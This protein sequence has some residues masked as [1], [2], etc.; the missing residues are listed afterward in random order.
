ISIIQ[1]NPTEVNRSGNQIVSPT[2]I[3]RIYDDDNQTYVNGSEHPTNGTLW[4]AYNGSNWDSGM[5]N[6]TNENGYVEFLFDPTPDCDYLQGVRNWIAGTINTTCYVDQN[7]TGTLPNITVYG[8]LVN[9]VTNVSCPGGYCEDFENVSI[10][11]RVLDKCDNPRNSSWVRFNVS[12]DGFE[13]VCEPVYNET[14]GYF[15]CSWNVTG[16]PGG[17]YD[18]YM[19]SNETYFNNGTAVNTSMFFH[20]IA[21]VLSAEY[22]SPTSVPWGPDDAKSTIYFYV[23]VTDDD[24]N[25]TL[26]LYL[27]KNVSN[28]GSPVDTDTTCTQ[29]SDCINTTKTLQYKF[30]SCVNDI[31]TWYWKINVTDSQG[32][33]DSTSGTDT[34]EVLKRNITFVEWEG[35]TTN[36]SRVGDNTTLIA[37]QV[38]DNYTGTGIG[39]GRQG[40]LWV[41]KDQAASEWGPALSNYTN[42]S[43]VF[44]YDFNGTCTY[45]V[46]EQKWKIGLVFAS[47][48][49]C[50]NDMNSTDYLVLNI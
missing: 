18:V 35:N 7:Y 13:D 26:R 3:I 31:G 36:V 16:N 19:W 29:Q 1:G 2:I 20:E 12:H 22:A 30:T 15:N 40:Y 5:K 34:V 50:Y 24:D 43:S 49:I 11:G 28:W 33:G 45:H 48:P 8:D 37:V 47:P 6:E 9:N 21:P 25:V 32:M 46:G 23:N 39:A 17:W 42:G 41:T 27:T 4:V 10:Q 14:N 38:F 44:S